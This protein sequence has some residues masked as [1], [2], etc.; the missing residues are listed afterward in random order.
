MLSYLDLYENLYKI[1]R[2][3]YAKKMATKYGKYL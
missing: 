3:K 1:E 2:E